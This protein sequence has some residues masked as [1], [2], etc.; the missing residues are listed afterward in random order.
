VLPF[1]RRISRKLASRAAPLIPLGV[2][3]RLMPRN[4]V[5]FFYHAVSDDPPPHIRH[6]YPIKSAAEFEADLLWLK[7]HFTLIGYPQLAAHARGER[8]L[9]ERAAYLSFDD[10][11]AEC[12]HVIRPLLLKHGIPAIFFLATDWIDNEGM[13]YKSKVS[14]VI[15]NRRSQIEPRDFRFSIF[16]LISMQ[17]SG[18]SL[19]NA[20]CAEAGVDVAAYLR[21][22][23]PFLTRP[24]IR[25]MRAEGFVFGGH[26]RRHHKLGLLPPEEQAAEMAA[27]CRI[28]AGI[29]G[30]DQV[31]FAFPFSGDGVDRGGIAPLRNQH[32]QV[33]L[34]FD[35]KKLRREPG[36]FHRIWADKP[37]KG[38]PP[39][40]SLAHWLKD[41]YAREAAPRT[42]SNA[43]AED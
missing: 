28:V 11:F 2:Y 21:A 40:R 41:A 8:P 13:Y 17:Q 33:G 16:D 6:L 42:A 23:Q 4:P 3:R 30:D 37:V 14:L 12:Y 32:P 25:E 9:P 24:Q 27:S 15:E 34:V 29:T 43:A 10:G 20:A 31:P 7:R 36:I 22:R 38:V 39:A 35:T 5:G 26:T 1:H 18:E 19:I